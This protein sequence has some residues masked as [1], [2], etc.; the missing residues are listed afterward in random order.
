MLTKFTFTLLFWLLTSAQSFAQSFEEVALEVETNILFNFGT[1][2]SN[3]ILSNQ[4]GGQYLRSIGHSSYSPLLEVQRK[5][6]G[7]SWI[8]SIK[9]SG[10]VITALRLSQDECN[11]RD[12]AASGMPCTMPDADKIDRVEL[13]WLGNNSSVSV[14]KADEINGPVTSGSAITQFLQIDETEDGS[15]FSLANPGAEL[16]FISGPAS[17]HDEAFPWRS[18]SQIPQNENTGFLLDQIQVTPVSGMR[19]GRQ[20]P[21][22][23]QIYDQ[24]IGVLLGGLEANSEDSIHFI[25]ESS[26]NPQTLA[27]W[28]PNAAVS[29]HDIE[30]FARCGRKPTRGDGGFQVTKQSANSGEPMFLDLPVCSDGWHIVISSTGTTN[31]I[32]NII[33]GEHYNQAN[34]DLQIMRVGIENTPASNTERDIIKNTIRQAVW[35]FYGA[36]GGSFLIRNIQYTENSCSNVHICIRNRPRPGLGGCTTPSAAANLSQ[37]NLHICWN[38]QN[39]APG[40]SDNPSITVARTI[41]HEMGHAFA[42][43]PDEYWSSNDFAKICGVS[44]VQIRRCSHSTMGYQW[45]ARNSLCTDSTHAQVPEFFIQLPSET[46]LTPPANSFA[47]GPFNVAGPNTITECFNGEVNQAGYHANAAWTT[48]F[49]NGVATKPHPNRSAN[50]FDYVVFANSGLTDLGNNGTY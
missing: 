41:V 37:G 10:P 39:L 40:A 36:T 17:V 7:N 9:I 48:L 49:G 31:H 19:R 45:T 2:D 4:N 8:G 43:L 3:D 21:I 20:N 24:I 1:N 44:G 23:I 6:I 5:I 47:T 32:V 16:T 25:V 42:H 22:T 50:N 34:R 35:R 14:I 33:A 11:E 26:T 12:I 15:I 27:V 29:V 38:L 46:T 18:Q 28:M 30:A 13:N